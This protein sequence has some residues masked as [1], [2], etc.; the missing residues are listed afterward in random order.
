MVHPLQVYKQKMAK[1]ARI[2]AGVLDVVENL[3]LA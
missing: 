1:I 2:F 3:Y